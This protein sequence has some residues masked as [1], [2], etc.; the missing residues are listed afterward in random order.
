M[1]YSN[2]PLGI[3]ESS[4]PPTTS[5]EGDS[6]H[7]GRNTIPHHKVTKNP[8]HTQILRPNKFYGLEWIKL[9]TF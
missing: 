7:T 4:S 2:F 1:C 5:D 9:H 8:R 6:H 3:A